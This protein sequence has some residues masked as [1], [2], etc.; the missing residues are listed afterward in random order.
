MH[1][2]HKTKERY[3]PLEVQIFHME[4]YSTSR[5]LKLAVSL[6]FDIDS[7]S[8][9]SFLQSVIDGYEDGKNSA[10]ISFNLNDL[11]SKNNIDDFWFYLGSITI[12]PCSNGRLNWLVSRKVYKMTQNEHDKL[13]KIL[14][15]GSEDWDGNYRSTQPV[16]D[17]VGF[18]HISAVRDLWSYMFEI[19]FLCIF[20]S[21]FDQHQLN[22]I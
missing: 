19:A 18:R 3:Y 14:S 7:S 13:K 2:E 11:I 12:P 17:K 4:L 1:S 6:F 5:N 22:P 21:Y 8:S 15:Q 9:S 10:K 20:Y 16:N